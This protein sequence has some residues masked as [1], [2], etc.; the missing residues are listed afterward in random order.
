MHGVASAQ[1]SAAPAAANA[2]PA[3]TRTAVVDMVVLLK[4]HPKLNADL[5]DFANQQRAI[6]TQLMNAER[7]L[8]EEARAMVEMHKP[9]T[10]DF[11]RKSEELDKKMATLNTERSKA[12]REAIL[13]DT[14][15]KYEA[16]KSIQEE[17]QNFSQTRGVAVVIDVRG[18]DP[19]ADELTNAEAEVGQPVVWSAPGV[20]MTI[21]IVQALNQ[22]FQK[23]PATANVVEGRDGK[24]KVVFLNTNQN[25]GGPSIPQRPGPGQSPPTATSPGNQGVRN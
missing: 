20:N 18:I 12:Q 13:R 23:F 6:Q 1:Q 21:P 16:F 4:S 15:I 22:R 8:Q 5:K 9:G 7:A 17:I 14:R 24:P 10:E 19:D 11:S 25:E 3:A 2:P